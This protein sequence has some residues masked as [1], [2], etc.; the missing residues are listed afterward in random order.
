MEFLYHPCPFTSAC[1][2][3][4]LTGVYHWSVDNYGDGN[5]PIVGEQIAAF[6]GHHKEPWTIT[7][8]EFC[9]NVHKVGCS[10]LGQLHQ[11]S[12][13]LDQ[14]MLSSVPACSRASQC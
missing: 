7:E 1:V 10:F 4:F 13:I 14:A 3:D 6:Q 5:T 9:N 12:T 8:R 11:N 2:A